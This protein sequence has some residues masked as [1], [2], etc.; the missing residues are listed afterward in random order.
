MYTSAELIDALRRRL[1]KSLRPERPAG[2]FP[3]GWSAWFAALGERLGVVTG[4]TA[5][6][7][8]ALMMLREPAPAP[9]AAIELNRWQSFA[10]LWRQQ[11]YPASKDERWMRVVAYIITFVI[12]L[13]L[14]VLLLWLAYVRFMGLP[15]SAPEGQ[16]TV[17]VE[18]I[19]EGTPQDRGGGPPRGD[20]A[21]TEDA[22]VAAS[23]AGEVVPTPIRADPQAAQLPSASD[24]AV[25]YVEI[26]PQ[27]PAP[28][29]AQ[30]LQVTEVATPDTA[31]VLPPPTLHPPRLPQPNVSVPE[32]RVPTREVEIAEIPS[33]IPP[34]THPLPQQQIA[35]PQ[36]PQRTADV[37]EREVPTPLPPVPTP[38]LPQRAVATPELRTQATRIAT[39][40]V[41]M[42]PGT[43]S[44]AQ[45]AAATAN[46]SAKS[47]EGVAQ[48][49]VAPRGNAVASSAATPGGTS[50]ERSG[51]Q[52]SAAAAGSGQVASPQPGA[53]PTAKRGDDWGA[54]NRNRPGGQT[55]RSPGLFNA[56][57][58]PKLAPGTAAP[59]GGLPPG[60][61][62]EKIANLDRAGSWLKR[63]PN[64]FE[65]TSFD[66]YWVPNETLLA[67]WVRKSIKQVLIPIPGTSK[68]IKC[69]VVLLALGGGCTIEDPNLQDVEAR[70]RS[71]PD[72][73]FKR[74]L[75]EDQKSLGKPP[76]S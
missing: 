54:S 9:R 7:I 21:Q 76:G 56:D 26:Q 40:D 69:S 52:P 18:F 57:G 2:E 8:V 63:K 34:I 59:G 39:R 44:N 24:A 43:P 10:T 36:I 53:F 35:A 22:A 48:T 13:V 37:A 16:S 74:E 46:P 28:S 75:Q 6:A 71:A 72:V 3:P 17:Q 20:T 49:D 65:P 62:E 50:P 1:R 47:D 42:P 30:P 15:A 27:P 45:P 51:S 58:S 60:T 19:G 33:L 32:L 41:P 31:F 12:H 67:E 4:A 23:S 68:K 64:D 25:P 29:S 5:E 11:W 66:K 14:A 73:P 38:A 70:A 55:G 61:I